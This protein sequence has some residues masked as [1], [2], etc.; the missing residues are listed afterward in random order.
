[1]STAAEQ[2]RQH[3]DRMRQLGYVLKQLWV[4]PREWPRVQAFIKGL[5]K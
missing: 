5:R 2:K 3:R 1:M 4:K